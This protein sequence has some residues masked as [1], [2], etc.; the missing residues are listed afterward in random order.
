MNK[1]ALS[2]ASVVLL[3]V[4]KLA[5]HGAFNQSAQNTGL[6][7]SQY[8]SALESGRDYQ[9]LY[10]DLNR[11]QSQITGYNPNTMHNDFVKDAALAGCD[12][13]DK[14]EVYVAVAMAAAKKQQEAS[15]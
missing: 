1:T 11:L 7:D 5:T 15:R 6:S 12:T 14:V 10:G 9:A 13:R 3:V 2:L 4:C 8:E